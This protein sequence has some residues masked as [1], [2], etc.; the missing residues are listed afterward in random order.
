MSLASFK[1]K[2][3]VL[4]WFNPQCPFVVKSH[5]KGSLIDTAKKQTDAGVVWLAINSGAAGKQ[6][7]ELAENQEAIKTWSLDPPGAARRDRRGRQGL[8]RHQ[9]AQHVRDRRERHR[10]L[11]RRHRQLARRRARARP[12]GGTLVN[13]VEAALADLA[14]GRPV[15]T[16]RHQAVRMRRQ[17]RV[18]IAV[19]AARRR[20]SRDKSALPDDDQPGAS[21]GAEA[22]LA[23][24]PADA[25]RVSGKH[26]HVDTAPAAPCAPGASCT[27]MAQL[28]ALDGYKVN[29]DYPFRFLL[30]P[31]AGVVL[32]GEPHFKVTATSTGR[33][34]VRFRRTSTPT[35]FAGSFKLSVCNPDE[36]VVETAALAVNIP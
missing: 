4:E 22:V 31:A 36:C 21:K 29:K 26:F 28:T 32:E 8:R 25:V 17:V 20:C 23:P 24:M 35:P 27:V 2:I 15:A 11:R 13:H 9:H 6:G 12:T 34:T 18:L 16:P 3:V 33:L 14:A 10:G 7:H 30:E 1:G 19:G 5:T